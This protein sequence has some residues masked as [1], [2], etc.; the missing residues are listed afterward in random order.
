[1]LCLSH[2]HSCC[3]LRGR[4]RR[5]W[6]LSEEHFYRVG[7]EI[8]ACGRHY[9]SKGLI[10]LQEKEIVTGLGLLLENERHFDRSGLGVEDAPSARPLVVS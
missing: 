2:A 5:R 4:A 3:S 7:E 8:F 1:L 10:V 6:E 9:P